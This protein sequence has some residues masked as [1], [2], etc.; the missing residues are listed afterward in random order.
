MPGRI[1]NYG[2]LELSSAGRD[3]AEVIFAGIPDPKS[4]K[5]LVMDLKQGSAGG[6]G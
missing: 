5:Q 4:V 3:E 2:T 1:L 6:Q